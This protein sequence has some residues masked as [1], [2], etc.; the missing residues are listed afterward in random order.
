MNRIIDKIPAAN[1]F[2]G[3]LL[4]QEVLNCNAIMPGISAPFCWNS[5][6][7]NIPFQNRRETFNQHA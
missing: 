6:S 3:K 2:S 1:Q 4:L 7:L 5:L